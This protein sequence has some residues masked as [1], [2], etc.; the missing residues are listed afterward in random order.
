MLRPSLLLITLG[1]LGCSPSEKSNSPEGPSA[2]LPPPVA[3]FTYT[4]TTV[5]AGSEV[6]F[7]ASTSRSDGGE[8]VAYSWDI[9]GDGGVDATGATAS[10]IMS[11]SG[12]YDVTLTVTDTNG[13]EAVSTQKVVVTIKLLE[14]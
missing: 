14:R 7:D 5:H 13:V 8:I 6:L 12:E 4:P 1:T 9:D 11:Y 3:S 2:Q 10:S